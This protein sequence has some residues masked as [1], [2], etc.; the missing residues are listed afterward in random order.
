MINTVHALML[1][2]EHP[3]SF[4][5]LEQVSDLDLQAPDQKRITDK[6]HG[7]REPAVSCI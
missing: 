4:K 6:I 2:K 3:A 1:Q 7:K 5:R